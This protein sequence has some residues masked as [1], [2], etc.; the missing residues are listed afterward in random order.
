MEKAPQVGSVTCAFCKGLGTDP[1]NVM[2]EL[3]TCTSCEGKGWC[4]VPVP[5]VRCAFCKGSG[6]FKTYRCPVCNGSGVTEAPREPANVCAECEGRAFEASSGL[7]CLN[8][9]GHG[10]VS[11]Q[12]TFATAGHGPDGERR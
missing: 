9:G 1:F 7:P 2:S 12:A 8:C 6:S 5:H 4:R 10:V 11:T 3:S